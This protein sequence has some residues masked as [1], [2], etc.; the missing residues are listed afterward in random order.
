MADNFK[1]IK[2]PACQHEMQKVFVPTEG[3]N[4]D[5]C[6]NGCGGIYFDNREYKYFDEQ[7]ENIDEICKSLNGKNLI[8]TDSSL[9]RTCPSC[10]ARMVKNYTSANEK[11]QID[12]CYSCGGKFLDHGELINIRAEYATEEERSADIVK[13]IYDTVGIEIKKLELENIEL[14]KKRSPLKK[15]F[16]KLILG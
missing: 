2:C 6:V 16:D 12:E 7:D 15:L 3:I 1:V 5:V 10:G 14:R 11:V 4:V 9:P 8:S 13:K